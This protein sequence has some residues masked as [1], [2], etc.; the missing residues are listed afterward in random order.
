V[1]NIWERVLKLEV[2]TFELLP[3]DLHEGTDWYNEN[4]LVRTVGLRAEIWTS[5]LSNVKQGWH[6]L[7][8]DVQYCVWNIHQVASSLDT[9]VFYYVTVRNLLDYIFNMR[10]EAKSPY[11]SSSW[12]HRDCY[13]VMLATQCVTLPQSCLW[14]TILIDKP[15]NWNRLQ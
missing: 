10:W 9:D 8:H 2:V 3:Q 12:T 15:V 14:L 7:Y 5:A 6:L 11:S 4:P 1:N 13:S